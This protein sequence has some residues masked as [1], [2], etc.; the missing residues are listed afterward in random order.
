M[1]VSE[2][3]I[4][5]S[6]RLLIDQHGDEAAIHAAMRADDLLDDGEVDGSS[7]W[8]RVVKAIEGLLDQGPPEAGT[9]RH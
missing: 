8:K 2:L 5:R 9:P 7:V 1:A 3:D 4:W 6:A